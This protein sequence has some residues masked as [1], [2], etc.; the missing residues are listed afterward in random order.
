MKNVIIDGNNA[1]VSVE[2]R[3]DLVKTMEVENELK[4]ALTQQGCT[5]IIID[6]INTKYIDS[7]ANRLFKKNRDIVGPD[8]IEF[9]NVVHPAI[10]KAIKTAKMDLIFKIS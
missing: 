3:F 5:K 7:S 2:G 9:K 10:Q 6:F 1:I 8:N 4:V